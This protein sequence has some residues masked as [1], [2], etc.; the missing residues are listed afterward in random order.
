MPSHGNLRKVDVAGFIGKNK[1]LGNIE[2]EAKYR[3]QFPGAGAY[4]LVHDK[5]WD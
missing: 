3:K 5:P 1:Q 4:T 2:A